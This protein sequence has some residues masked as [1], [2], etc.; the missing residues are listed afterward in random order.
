MGGPWRE[1]V[2]FKAPSPSVAPGPKGAGE[3]SPAT[4]R[5]YSFDLGVMFGFILGMAL[6]SVVW[7]VW[8]KYG[9]N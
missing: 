9:I 8:F 1:K 4:G 7:I 5:S 2:P 3:A 6:T